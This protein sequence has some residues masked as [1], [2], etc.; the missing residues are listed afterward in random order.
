MQNLVLRKATH[1]DMDDILR[2]Q[3]PVFKG[4]QGIPDELIPIPAEK[5]PQWWCAI[6]NSTIVGTGAAWK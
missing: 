1:E 6:M 4:E 5:S 2:L 3:I